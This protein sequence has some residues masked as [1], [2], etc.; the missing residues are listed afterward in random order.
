MMIMSG[1]YI[2]FYYYKLALTQCNY[3]V[4]VHDHV[5]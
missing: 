2:N 4:F 3:Q 5:W 1:K